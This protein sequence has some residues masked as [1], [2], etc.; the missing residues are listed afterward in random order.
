MSDAVNSVPSEPVSSSW[1]TK[2]STLALR[3][4]GR[5]LVATVWASAGLFGLYILAFYAAALVGGHMQQWNHV[6]PGL[7]VPGSRASTSGI[8]LHFAAG[9][10]ILILGSS[11]LLTGLRTRFPAVH[12]WV[13]RIYV[14]ASV[15]AAVGGLLFI[16]LKGTIG[17]TVMNAG[18]A[19]YG[20][21]TLVAAVET[22]RH[23]VA[24]R[25]AQ[26]R[27][28]SLLLYALAIGTWLYRM[29]YGFW[30]MATDGLG[31]THTFSGLF[32]KI[33]AFFFYL[34]NLLVVEIFLRARSRAVAPVLRLVAAGALLL[35][36]GFLGLGTYYFT[37]YYWGPAILKWLS[38]A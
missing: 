12:R 2:P 20:L 27:A 37:L 6:L 9:G 14:S 16:G 17:G 33:M 21:L 13:G 4:S 3:W 15:L 22:Y 31:H 19:L 38:L 34:P 29:D 26:H 28:W 8:G 32:D 35:A 30:I 24:G 36:T 10:I 7:Y 1:L 23:A 11:Q 5:L 18:F 25:L